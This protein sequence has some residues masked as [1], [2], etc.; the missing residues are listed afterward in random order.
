[1]IFKIFRI[2]CIA[3]LPSALLAMDVEYDWDPYKA[4]GIERPVSDIL[5]LPLDVSFNGS[6]DSVVIS[7]SVQESNEAMVEELTESHRPKPIKT[8]HKIHECFDCGRISVTAFCLRAHRA[9]FHDPASPYKCPSCTWRYNDL[10]SL[11]LHVKRTHHQQLTSAQEEELR[12]AAA[13]SPQVKTE[14]RATFQKKPNTKQNSR[15]KHYAHRDYYGPRIRPVSDKVRKDRMRV[16]GG[17]PCPLCSARSCSPDS[18]RR[19]KRQCHNEKNSFICEEATCGWRFETNDR[20]A[21][22]KKC[23]HSFKLHRCPL[24]MC[25]KVYQNRTGLAKHLRDKHKVD[26]RSYLS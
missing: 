1:M 25:T 21:S 18:L 4:P 13:N 26:P 22:H 2:A 17:V 11:A 24:N 14:S 6:V 20:L 12:G 15:F 16:E 9:R 3:L 8:A 10:S 23:K 5:A 7:G 19:H